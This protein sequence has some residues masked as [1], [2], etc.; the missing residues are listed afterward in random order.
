MSKQFYFTEDNQ[1]VVGQQIYKLEDIASVPEVRERLKKYIMDNFHWNIDETGLSTNYLGG[2]LQS[3]TKDPNL[4]P[5]STFLKNNN[6]DKITLIPGLLEFTDK[7][8]G[9]VKDD[10]GNKNIDSSHPD[11]ISV[12][13]WYIKQGILLTDI[14]DTMRDAN[15]YIDDVMLVDKTAERK[16]EQAQ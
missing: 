3:Q 16:I 4:Y 7:D 11:G 1:L 10:N 14:A 9:I 2:S 6:I 13:G 5:L 8:F 15:I 12:L